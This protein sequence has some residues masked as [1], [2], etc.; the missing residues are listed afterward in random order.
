MAVLL[1]TSRRLKRE[2]WVKRVSPFH[3][4]LPS[5]PLPHRL[6]IIVPREGYEHINKFCFNLKQKTLIE[7]GIEFQGSI[8]SLP[9]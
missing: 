3:V 1:E 8:R 6:I 2:G 5:E 7:K 4:S 9:L